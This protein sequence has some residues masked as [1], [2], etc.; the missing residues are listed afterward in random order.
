MPKEIKYSIKRRQFRDTVQ[1]NAWNFPQWKTVRNRRDKSENNGLSR[2]IFYRFS[3]PS[4]AL[5]VDSR[6][7][8]GDEYE[9]RRK[10]NQ[11]DVYI[12][13]LHSST[14]ICLRNK[15][16][17]DMRIWTTIVLQ[18]EAILSGWNVSF[19]AL[20]N[21]RKDS[22]V[23]LLGDRKRLRKV[24]GNSECFMKSFLHG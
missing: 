22:T 8:I 3:S 4:G 5:L 6:E 1:D 7:S 15:L 18:D 14:Y 23:I 10:K 17:R 11:R 20:W 12:S 16:V 2:D 19:D 13:R 9:I 21:L 24:E